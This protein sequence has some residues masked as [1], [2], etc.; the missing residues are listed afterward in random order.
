MEKDKMKDFLEAV[1]KN[2]PSDWLDL[3]TH[4]LD[5][6]EEKLAK[7]QFLD[8]FEGLYSSN[9]SDKSVLQNLPTAYDYIRL[10]HP[11]SCIFYL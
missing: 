6:Y 8:H 11:L 7:S 4:R 2:M 5:I 3:T 10:G 9:T 1:L